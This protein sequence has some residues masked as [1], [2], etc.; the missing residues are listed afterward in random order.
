[1]IRTIEELSMNAFPSLNTLY[2]DG[3]VIR[4][5]DGVTRRVN[6]VYS[7]YPSTLEL[8]EKVS[9]CESLFEENGLRKVFKLTDME[10]SSPLEDFLLKRGYTES[11]RTHIKTMDLDDLNFSPDLDI[12]ILSDFSRQWFRD[13]CSAKSLSG[14]DKKVYGDSWKMVLPRQCFISLKKDGTRFA[15]GRGVLDSGYIGIYGIYVHEEFRRK[16]YGEV[17]TT[18]LMAYGRDHGCQSAYLQV[19]DD[20][21]KAIRL[22]EKI[23]F[24]EQYQYWYLLRE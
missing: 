6:S 12:E 19:E 2:Y 3:W 21:P 4:M 8:E 22:Y 13:L 10:T 20:N 24:E 11:G 18:A 15:F 9:H 5:S 1:M 14:I 16:G 23:G 17:L 7:L